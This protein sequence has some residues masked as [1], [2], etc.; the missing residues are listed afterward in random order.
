[1]VTARATVVRAWADR[2]AAVFFGVPEVAFADRV[3]LDAVDPVRVV[4]DFA[5]ALR[6]ELLAFWRAAVDGF[7]GV[8]L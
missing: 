6:A 2:A 4:R 7:G 5:G 1:M 3:G 8:A